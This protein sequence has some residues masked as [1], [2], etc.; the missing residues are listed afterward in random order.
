MPA[1]DFRLQPKIATA[2]EIAVLVKCVSHSDGAALIEQYA[3]T[4]AAGAALDATNEAHNRISAA[5]EGK[6]SHA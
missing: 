3:R 4:I 5:I 6:S 1:Y 2:L